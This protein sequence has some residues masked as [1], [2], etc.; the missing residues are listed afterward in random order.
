MVTIY[1]LIMVGYSG[2]HTQKFTSREKCAEA[3]QILS[4]ELP[5]RGYNSISF[6][7]CVPK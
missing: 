7:V 3:A 4:A 6:F 2:F 1:V 5:K